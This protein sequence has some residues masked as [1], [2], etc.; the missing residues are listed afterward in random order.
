LWVLA[1]Y[2]VAQGLMVR[3]GLRTPGYQLEDLIAGIAD[4]NAHDEVD[5]G[6]PVGKEAL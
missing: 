5:F 4:E 3:G 2:Y 1:T 6:R